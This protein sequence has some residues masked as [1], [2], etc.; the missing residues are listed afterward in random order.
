MLHRFRL[1]RREDGDLAP[2]SEKTQ[3]DTVRVFVKWIGAID[4]VEPNLQT[5]VR[6]PTLTGDDNVRSVML[7]H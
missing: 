1:W 2:A 5:K 7:D 6:S 3:M 4:A